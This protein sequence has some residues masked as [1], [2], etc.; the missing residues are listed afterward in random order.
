MTS[1]VLRLIPD[2]KHTPPSGSSRIGKLSHLRWTPTRVKFDAMRYMAAALILATACC[3]V[4]GYLLYSRS[5]PHEDPFLSVDT[6]VT[7]I[8]GAISVGVNYE[9]FSEKVQRLSTTILTAGRIGADAHRLRL[10]STALDNYKDS[11]DVWSAKIQYSDGQ[12]TPT[13]PRMMQKYNVEQVANLDEH[14][15]YF[16]FDRTIKV[17]WLRAGINV[18][19]ARQSG[20]D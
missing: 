14:T 16:N 5:Q 15:P 11:L 20:K 10:Y 19:L 12:Y 18:A 6:A 1:P 7:D 13:L 2:W 17:I 8:A 9:R 4:L 3:G